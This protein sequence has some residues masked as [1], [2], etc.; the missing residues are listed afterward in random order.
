[1]SELSFSGYV[2]FIISLIILYTV[3][4]LL[5]REIQAI[6]L[7]LTKEASLTIGIYSFLLFPGVFIHEFSHLIM[8]FILRVPIKKFS[9]IPKT[10]ENGQLQMGYVQTRQTNFF[11]DALIGLAPFIVGLVLTAQISLNKLHFNNLIDGLIST[12]ASTIFKEM[13]TITQQNDFG[14]WFYLAFAISSTML[15]SASDRQ[16]WGQIGIIFFIILTILVV[17][18]IGPWVLTN[19]IPRVNHWFSSIAIVIVS[20]DIVHILILF[21]VFILR[22]IV[23]RLLRISVI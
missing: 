7:I 10:L 14:V 18:G 20:S 15:P 22:K 1:M 11:K 19:I 17:V 16:S 6:L 23:S 8:A 2:L 4:R 21:P 9:L 3:Q 5:H 12:N 13:S